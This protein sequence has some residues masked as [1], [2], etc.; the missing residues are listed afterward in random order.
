MI[1]IHNHLLFG[2]D[3]GSKT[4]LNSVETLHNLEEIGYTDIILTPHYIENTRYASSKK[5]NLKILK[6]L[7]DTLLKEKININLYLGNEIFINDNI[8]SL[9]EKEE[10]A[11]L[12]DSK[13]ILI[14]LPMSGEYDSYFDV[15]EELIDHGYHPI[16][17]HPERYLSFQ[18]DFNKAIE[19]QKLGVYLQGNI[20][21]IIGR[22]GRDAKKTVKK[23]L[24]NKMLTFLATD[25]H[26]NKS[27]YQD[28]IIAKKK[29]CKYITEDEYQKLV[30]INPKKILDNTVIE[31]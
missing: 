22:Y 29:I 17:A 10:I 26:H 31:I 14:E 25:I 18:E 19:L 6:E 21:S 30:Y 24:K 13:Y 15:F 20:E 1:D 5:N 12:N 16:L 8:L 9:L 3:D 28:Y 2:V 7:K 27:D 23:L 11:C 4:I